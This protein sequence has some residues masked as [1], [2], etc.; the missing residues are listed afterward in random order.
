MK[1]K[2]YEVFECPGCFELLSDPW[3]CP[4]CGTWVDEN[5]R[6]EIDTTADNILNPF[7]EI[8]LDG[9]PAQEAYE[10]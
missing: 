7:T 9:T 3:H 2:R 10:A 5:C 6:K 4:V 1:T 8:Y